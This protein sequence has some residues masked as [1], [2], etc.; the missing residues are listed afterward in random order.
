MMTNLKSIG[1][2]MA[3]AA[4]ATLLLL[5]AFEPVSTSRAP[6][7]IAASAAVSADGAA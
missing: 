5:A 4:A 7:Q 6:S 1:G 2:G 3:W